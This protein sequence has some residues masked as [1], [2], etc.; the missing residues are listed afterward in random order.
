L[1]AR[2]QQHLHTLLAQHT[3]AGGGAARVAGGAWV[4]R[5]R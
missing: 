2:L 3:A 5:K 1:Q 4:V